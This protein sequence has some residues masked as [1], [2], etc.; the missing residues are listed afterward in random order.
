[1]K[2]TQLRCRYHTDNTSMTVSWK[3]LPTF[4]HIC[5]LLCTTGAVIQQFQLEPANQTV[6]QGSDVKFNATVQG[7]WLFMTWSVGD[8]LVLTVPVESNGT[9]SLPQ[10]SA[11]FCSTGDPS[12]VEFTIHNVN[13][14]TNGLV[15]CSV[16]G[17]YGSKTAQ[18]NVQVPKPPTV[19]KPPDWTVLIAVVVSFGGAALLA[20]LILGIIFCCNRRK[21]KQ[22]NYQDEM[23]RRVRTQ[24]QLSTVSEAALRRGQANRGFEP[25]GQTS[26]SP[27]E[28]TDSGSYQANGPIAYQMPDI[29]NGEQTGNGYNSAQ[30]TLDGSGF[31]K[32]RHLTFV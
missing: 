22:S 26:V 17:A 13:R 12:C 20:L 18:F 24:S 5:L 4:L 19:P 14:S 1:M 29:L 7:Q 3:S 8:N 28:L 6:L 25:E 31:R 10:F 15:T 23:S 2:S 30:H 9:S 27:S 32:H 16:Q 21:E 11:K